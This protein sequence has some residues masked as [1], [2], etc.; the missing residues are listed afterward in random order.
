MNEQRDADPAICRTRQRLEL[1]KAEVMN[2][3]LLYRIA[4]GLLVVFAASHT[5]G[6]LTFDESSS[7]V[8]GVREAMDHVHFQLMGSNCSY[9]G[10]YFGFGLLLTAYL[11][12]SAFLAWHLGGLARRN[13]QAIGALAWSLFTVQVVNLAL[14]WTYFFPAPVAMSALVA[15]CLGWAAWLVTGA[16]AR[17]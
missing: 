15:I 8:R 4:S 6:L 16:R 2:A 14:S 7:E 9:G 10:F 17:A 12:F 13:P 11:L 3:T 5:S 1:G